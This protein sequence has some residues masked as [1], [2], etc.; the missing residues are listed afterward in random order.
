[1]VASS[2]THAQLPTP[3]PC[4]ILS[5]GA[6]ERNSWRKHCLTFY[7]PPVPQPLLVRRQLLPPHPLQAPG[8]WS[9]L[10]KGSAPLPKP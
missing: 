6:D 7:C 5:Q 3:V 8:H 9:A 10:N 4:M 1:M 2:Q